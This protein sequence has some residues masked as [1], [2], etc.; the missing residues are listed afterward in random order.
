MNKLTFFSQ[1]STVHSTFRRISKDDIYQNLQNL[2][3]LTF[4]VTDACNLRCFYCGYG[5]LYD[6]YDHRASINLSF[7]KCRN[8]IDY[9]VKI[10]MNAPS[11]SYKQQCLISFYGGEPLLNVPLISKIIHYIEKLSDT[12]RVF[13]YSMTTNAVLLD[14]YIDFLVNNQFKLL[15]SLDGDEFGHSY[16]IDPKGHNSFSKVFKNVKLLQK[17]YP[18]YFE[19]FVNFNSVLHNRNS[20]D[21]IYYFIKKEFNKEPSI[22]EVNSLG[23]KN[24][25]KEIFNKVYHNKQESIY[26]APNP[27]QLIKDLMVTAPE[28][29][30]LASFL[31]SNSGNMF[32]DY[33]HLLRSNNYNEEFVQTGTCSPFGKKLFVTVNGKLLPCERIGHQHSLGSVSE[34]EVELNLDQVASHFNYFLDK[35]NHLCCSCY[36]KNGCNVCI[37]TE[38]IC[39][40]TLSCKAFMTRDQFEAFVY[41]QHEL[42]VKHPWLYKRIMEEVSLI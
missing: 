4:E 37:F 24:E 36:K 20:V 6:D 35:L 27:T 33:N 3:Q 38:S 34:T 28:V 32:F 29:Y 41:Q 11:V 17:T 26:E 42:L 8:I 14:K 25:K 18:D 16:R 2:S 9:L 10:W 30:R 7:T 19:Q 39:N 23:I 1:N 15:I 22:S 13:K 21:S 12:G 5:E 40:N 31:R